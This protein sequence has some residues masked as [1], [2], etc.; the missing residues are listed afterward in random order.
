M[1]ISYNGYNSSTLT[2]EADD[3]LTV[4]APVTVDTDGKA[5]TAA[6][7]EYF[8]GICTA[9]RGGWASVQTDGYVEAE[10]TGDAPSYG[11]YP[12][13]AGA[14]GKVAAGNDTSLI[15]YKILKIDETN[16]IVGFIL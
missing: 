14:N 6:Q 5:V 15:P 16:K 10:Y 9:I 13:I 12:I 1:S 8:I 3:E 11:I 7:G 2:F 4:G